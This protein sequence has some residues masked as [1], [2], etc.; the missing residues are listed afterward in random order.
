MKKV[1]ILV[2][3]MV[4]M[5]LM[6]Q[7]RPTQRGIDRSEG[8]Y[9]MM[10]VSQETKQVETSSKKKKGVEAMKP[11][12]NKV[13]IRFDFGKEGREGTEAIAQ[14][15]ASFTNEVDALTFLG[16]QGWRIQHVLET[17]TARGKEYRFYMMR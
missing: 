8:N 10:V 2:V 11:A 1:L 7:H 17:S 14:E 16:R 3:L 5:F 6:A 4:P 13:N 9:M 15:G 12:T